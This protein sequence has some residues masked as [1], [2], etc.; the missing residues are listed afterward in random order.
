MTLSEVDDLRHVQ[1]VAC[2]MVRVGD[3]YIYIYIAYYD[4][5]LAYKWCEYKVQ[6][7]VDVFRHKRWTRLRQ[8]HGV[9][10]GGVPGAGEGG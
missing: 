5:G 1:K 6:K 9:S 2:S 3:I 8:Q 10:L 7:V 4:D